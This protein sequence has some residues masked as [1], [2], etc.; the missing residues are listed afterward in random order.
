MIVTKII[1]ILT[2]IVTIVIEIIIIAITIIIATN[3]PHV[4]QQWTA[5]IWIWITLVII[6]I[7]TE[8]T[9]ILITT[10]EN[11]FII[12]NQHYNLSTCCLNISASNSASNSISN[13]NNIKSHQTLITSQYLQRYSL[14]MTSKKTFNCIMMTRKENIH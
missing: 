4:V 11:S 10:T 14:Y 1:T 2:T 6:E 8:I 12:D 7:V 9:I 3:S 13:N 5:T